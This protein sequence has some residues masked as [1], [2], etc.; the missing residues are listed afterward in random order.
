MAERAGD[1]SGVANELTGDVS[2]PY[3]ASLLAQKLGY[4]VSTGE[5]YYTTGCVS[6]SQ[7]VFPNATIPQSAWSAP[8]QH[9]LP[10]IPLP[11]DG[12]STFTTGA[13]GEIT[14]DDKGSSRV[15]INTDHWG[16]F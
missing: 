16:A 7:C 8:A 1:L 10:Y 9:L 4:S 12:S 14:R 2:G 15:D 6:S 13:N 11:N 3:L 5:P